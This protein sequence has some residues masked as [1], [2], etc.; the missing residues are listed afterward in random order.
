MF[1]I[2]KQLWNAKQGWLEV[3][4]IDELYK[5]LGI[6]ASDEEIATGIKRKLHE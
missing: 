2:L 1:T 6:N 5:E 3:S 4:Q